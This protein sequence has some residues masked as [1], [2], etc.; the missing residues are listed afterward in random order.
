LTSAL[1]ATWSIAPVFSGLPSAEGG[2]ETGL[3]FFGVKWEING[4]TLTLTLQT[5]AGTEGVVTLPGVGP[6]AVNKRALASSSNSVELKG[7][8]YTLT[9]QL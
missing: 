9:R 8:N 4:Q 2:L 5:P 1:G 7:G 6:M 3:G